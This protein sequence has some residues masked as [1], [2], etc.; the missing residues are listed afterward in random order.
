MRRL[1]FT[2]IILFTLPYRIL[3]QD[4]VKTS[5]N[6]EVI[7]TGPGPEDMLLDQSTGR[8]II[9]C[10]DF[11]NAGKPSRKGSINFYDPSTSNAGVFTIKDLPSGVQFFPHGIAM[12]PKENKLYVIIHDNNYSLSGNGIVIFDINGDELRYNTLLKDEDCLKTPNDLTVA[13]NGSV[14]VTNDGGFSLWEMFSRLFIRRSFV[15]RYDPW[16]KKFDRAY[17][18]LAVANGIHAIGNKVYIVDSFKKRIRETEI[19]K[20]G[21]LKLVDKIKVARSLDNITDHNGSLYIPEHE[22]ALKL[23][24]AKKDREVKPGFTV[25]KI[26]LATKTPSVIYTSTNGKPISS[27]STALYHDGHLYLS[28]IFDD[29]IVKIKKPYP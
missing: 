19:Q 10:G 17:K 22:S 16:A 9:S 29:F 28:Q 7:S 18:R 4:V 25:H 13:E 6:I 2:F 27:V 26:D 21:T 3:A 24:K 1:L 14:Y 20:D 11:F 23:Q 12:H 8:L 5:D 15:A